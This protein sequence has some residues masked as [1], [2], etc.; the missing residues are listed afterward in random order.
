[1]KF[2][3][4]TILW[5]SVLQ[6]NMLHAQK[7]T[8]SDKILTKLSK[9]IKG[10]KTFYVEYSASVKNE[11]LGQND[12]YTGKG[13]VKNNKYF[14]TY[15]DNTLISNGLKTWSIIGKDKE[16]YESNNSDEEE[17]VNPKKLMTLWE[18]GFKNKFI[19]SDKIGNDAVDVIEL[20]PKVPEK[21]NY[22]TITVYIGSAANELKKAVMKTTDGTVMTYSVTKFTSNPEVKD[23]KFTFDKKNYPGYKVIKN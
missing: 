10:L 12:S 18:S 3:L 5:F 9:K 17:S 20:Y 1:M 14:A 2:F 11:D 7:E 15:G 16:V 8:K 21:S 4:F 19:K 23:T 22:T 13:W 6:V